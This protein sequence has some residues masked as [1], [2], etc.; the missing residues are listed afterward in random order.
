[1]Y[2]GMSFQR[3]NSSR[4]VQSEEEKKGGWGGSDRF[5]T[6]GQGSIPHFIPP[7]G[8]GATHRGVS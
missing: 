2:L 4:E 8:E 6:S 3:G 5:G 7:A 1:M